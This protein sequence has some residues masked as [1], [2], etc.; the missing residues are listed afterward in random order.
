M[1][2]AGQYLRKKW[3]GHTGEAED[4]EGSQLQL[5]GLRAGS[6]LRKLEYTLE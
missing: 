3:K 1:F 2:H 5:P 4:P 6:R